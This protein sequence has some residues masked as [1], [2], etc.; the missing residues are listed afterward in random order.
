[1]WQWPTY[2]VLPGSPA[3]S[4]S[5]KMKIVY[6]IKQQHNNFS[7]KR[8]AVGMKSANS[9]REVDYEPFSIN[10]TSETHNMATKLKI[11]DLTE[12]K[13]MDSAALAMVRGGA[14]ASS[15]F[16][17]PVHGAQGLGPR[18]LNQFIDRS[19]H[20]TTIQQDNDVIYAAEG[21]TVTNIGGNYSSATNVSLTLQETI[22]A[23]VNGMVQSAVDDAF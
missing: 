21:A 3:F 15:L 9:H 2:G 11:N 18:I 22:T 7:A 4:T 5:D 8:M 23:G 14:A 20:I 12:V 17:H 19:Q 13:S 6:F 10:L 16:S 1:M